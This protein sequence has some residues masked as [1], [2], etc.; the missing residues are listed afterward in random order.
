MKENTPAGN[1]VIGIV[2]FLI[3][4]AIIYVTKLSLQSR[5]PQKEKA[6]QPKYNPHKKAEDVRKKN[7][8]RQ[9]PTLS[10]VVKAYLLK[11]NI[12]GTLL[13][14]Q[15]IYLLKELAF[16][17]IYCVGCLSINTLTLW[18]VALVLPLLLGSVV[19]LEYAKAG[20]I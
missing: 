8:Y 19:A 7:A 14:P 15:K 3:I 10:T 11:Y 6:K 2:Y 20:R 12:V 17:S 1:I 9:I 13:N 16:L 18:P 5:D 4:S